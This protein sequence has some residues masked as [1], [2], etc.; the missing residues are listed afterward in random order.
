MFLV[1]KGLVLFLETVVFVLEFPVFAFKTVVLVFEV[2]FLVLEFP[3]LVRELPVLALE[4]GM[5]AQ[6][7]AVLALKSLLLVLERAKEVESTS[8][9]FIIFELAARR[10]SS[11]GTETFNLRQRVK[12][13]IIN[14]YSLRGWVLRSGS[15]HV[16][17]V[18]V[19]VS[20]V[21]VVT[22]MTSVTVSANLELIYVLPAR[23]LG[24]ITFD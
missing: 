15:I 5:L 9:E 10:L 16:G 12:I 13:I 18:V 11:I 17:V 2:L 6:E 8:L 23:R 24:T 22:S 3:V 1:L 19:V 7:L 20:V 14:V 4:G 21:S